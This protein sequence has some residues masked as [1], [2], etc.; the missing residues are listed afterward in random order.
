MPDQR[1]RQPGQLAVGAEPATPLV[2]FHAR[3]AVQFLQE[4]FAGERLVL[5]N[6]LQPSP[7]ESLIRFKSLRFCTV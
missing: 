5:R 2:L 7:L 4:L 3:A 1:L 6:L